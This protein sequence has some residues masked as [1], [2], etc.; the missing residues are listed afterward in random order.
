MKLYEASFVGA[1]SIAIGVTLHQAPTKTPAAAT[2]T[3]PAALALLS[4]RF[5]L[6]RSKHTIIKMRRPSSWD[7][8]DMGKRW[9][10]NAVCDRFRRNNVRWAEVTTFFELFEFMVF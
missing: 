10:W 7:H 3:T 5:Q 9:Y 6:D 2:T 4:R 8:E 1:S